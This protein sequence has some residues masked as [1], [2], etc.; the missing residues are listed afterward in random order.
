MD[1]RDM[2]TLESEMFGNMELRRVRL[3]STGKYCV[4][5]KTAAAGCLPLFE[6]GAIE[7]EDRY[8]QECR[9]AERSSKRGR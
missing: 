2:D 7:V 1:E 9:K 6:G 3:F 5:L 8:D 4:V